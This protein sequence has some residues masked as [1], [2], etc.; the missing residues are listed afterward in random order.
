MLRQQQQQL[1]Q[2][3]MLRQQQK[4][5]LLHQQLMAA[6]SLADISSRNHHHHLD[7]QTSNMNYGGGAYSIGNQL[8]SVANLTGIMTNND[9]RIQPSLNIESI[10]KQAF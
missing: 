2:E 1:Q 10:I 4:Y 3:L 8:S 7:N 5:Y 6:N 9:T